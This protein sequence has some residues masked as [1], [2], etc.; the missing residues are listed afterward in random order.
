MSE[1]SQTARD[2]WL[3]RLRLS[4][5]SPSQPSAR[6][7]RQSRANRASST[8]RIN[9]KESSSLVS[10]SSPLYMNQITCWEMLVMFAIIF[11]KLI[12]Q[13]NTY[14]V[15]GQEAFEANKSFTKR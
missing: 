9:Y 14:I 3:S 2:R 4:K 1:V 5:K 6:Q 15:H 7:T 10:T 8:A 13:M 12:V 11:T